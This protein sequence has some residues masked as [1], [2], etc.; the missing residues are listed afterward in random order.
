MVL[1]RTFVPDIISEIGPMLNRQVFLAV[2][3]YHLIKIW[4]FKVKRTKVD[5]RIS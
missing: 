3:L 5:T 2:V 1:A 4:C